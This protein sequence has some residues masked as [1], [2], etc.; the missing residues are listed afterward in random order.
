MIRRMT[1]KNF[2]ALRSVQV[3]LE[4]FTVLI[5]L[6]DAGKTSFLEAVYALGEST[7]TDL[8][9]CFWSPWQSRELVHGQVPD[10]QVE[11]AAVLTSSSQPAV[12]QA[13]PDDTLAYSLSL[14]FSPGL[15]CHVAAERI[16][17]ATQE[18]TE[19]VPYRINHVATSV[20]H[21]ERL[22]GIPPNI[23]Q[24]LRRIAEYLPSAALARWDVEELGMPS[25]L[26]PDRRYP[27]DPSGHGLATCIAEMKLGRSGHFEALRADFC[28]QFP[29]FQDI[30]I[31]RTTVYSSERNAQFQKQHGPS[32]EG[33]TLVLVRKDGVEI[34]AGLAS[35]GTLVTLAFLTL[36][37]L[38][39]PRKLLL[40]EEPEN[41]LHPGRLK[42]IV[43]LLR[44][45]VKAH[46]D[47]Q[48]I[49]TTHSPLLL[50]HV[51]P[52]EV[53]VFLRNEHDDV[54]VYNVGQVPDIRQRLKYLMLG[55]LVY[56][57]GEQELVKEIQEHASSHSRR[58]AD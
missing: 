8:A 56:N 13:N 31:Q 34:P 6:N 3:E 43:P 5:G 2:K 30:S 20:C 45:A 15:G 38:P 7:R 18:A 9:K 39:E 55:E 54:E 27:I 1:V 29:A 51:E 35:G 17:S 4:P 37:H 47:S 16:G 58:G 12:G 48:V 41:A 19:E 32:G 36:I 14:T 40:I 11:F 52:S 10:T 26:P 46:K 21:R 25:R 28:N 33:Y 50:D 24:Q 22:G 42:E 57:E 49:I 44:R 53:R 23:Q